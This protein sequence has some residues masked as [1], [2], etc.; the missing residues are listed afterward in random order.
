MP[1]K[2]M[3]PEWT[4]PAPAWQSVWEDTNDPLIAGYFGIQADQ[5]TLLDG[6]AASA[7]SADHGPAI[8][9]QG[10]YPD[11]NGIANY[12]YIG[13]WH[14]SEYRQWWANEYISGWWNDARRLKENV[15]Y[16]REI[17]AM[18]FDRFET[19]HSTEIAHGVGVSADGIEGPIMEHGY[20]G[21]MRDRIALSEHHD[22]RNIES[23]STPLKSNIKDSGAR[24]MVVP[25]ENLCVIRSGQNWSFC[26][27]EEKNY[28][29]NKVHPVLLE[30][31]RFLRDNPIET[32]CYSLRFVD[33]KNDGW[34]GTEESFGLGY[35]ADI[36]A[37][38][39]WAKS[40]PTHLAIFGSFMK[41]VETFADQMK[42]RLWHEVTVL[43]GSGCE[44]EYIQ[45]HPDT[46]LLGYT[47]SSRKE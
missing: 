23:V 7:F 24:V 30:G 46:G 33:K 43:P 2:N 37:F 9:E 40:H 42:L 18:P 38:E 1:R 45:C 15:G 25:P 44:F 12:L 32:N 16:W 5:P 27:D 47:D 11:R 10:M 29:L 41:M 8:L 4:P 19:L 20:P 39:N 26:G 31:M 36:Y 35:A 14:Q 21:G 13:Y 3:P 28:Y 6:W 17:I 22:L 34:G